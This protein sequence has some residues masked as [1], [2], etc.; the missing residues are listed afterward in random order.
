MSKVEFASTSTTIETSG[1]MSGTEI[2]ASV[3]PHSSDS[4][5]PDFFDGT[6]KHAVTYTEQHLK[7]L[8]KAQARKNID[9]AS[10]GE[11]D[12][13]GSRINDLEG[14]HIGHDAYD[15]VHKKIEE[16][17]KRVTELEINAGGGTQFYTDLSRDG[18]YITVACHGLTAGN[19]YELHLYTAARR[20]GYRQDPWRHP[21]NENTGKGFTGKGYFNLA[22]QH[23]ECKDLNHIY[24]DVPDWMPRG[25]I[26]QTEWSF[27]A[28][29]E[30][31][32][33]D[34]DLTT[35]LLPMLKPVDGHFSNEEYMLIGV[36]STRAP[37]LMQF[38]PVFG[39]TVGECRDTLRVGVARS[40][41]GGEVIKLSNGGI[42]R[43]FL[44]T[45][46][47]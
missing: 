31:E 6:T 27:V 37:L 14:D 18:R 41:N 33:V 2:E 21:S 9:A 36:H 44:Y 11:V 39:N 25:G 20:R 24:E 26:L 32:Y 35:W 5:D 17:G 22:G 34:I 7:E 30:T 13:L 4:F 40:G 3:T 8:Q 28:T 12:E 15:C 29:A 47:K 16:V 23:Y 1:Y 42:H 38:R 43:T 19:T 45:S 10:Q 46:I